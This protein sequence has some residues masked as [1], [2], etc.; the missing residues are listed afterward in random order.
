MIKIV[1]FFYQFTAWFGLHK[2]TKGILCC[3][4]KSIMGRTREEMAL[5]C[6]VTGQRSVVFTCE[7]TYWRK[8]L[9]NR[10]FRKEV[11]WRSEVVRNHLL[12]E[13]IEAT[14][15]V[16][17]GEKFTWENRVKCL[18][19]VKR[20]TCGWEIEYIFYGLSEGRKISIVVCDNWSTNFRSI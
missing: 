18:W 8:R 15:T 1:F 16:R 9:I 3:I 20:P 7:C 19:I 12:G 13:I 5:F 11:E 17:P 2:E 6:L 14:Q 4:S 10:G